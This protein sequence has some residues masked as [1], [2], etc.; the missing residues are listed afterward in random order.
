MSDVKA[1]VIFQNFRHQ[2]VHA[3][4]N[5]RQQHQNVGALVPFSDG[6][7]HGGDLPAQ[8]FDAGKQ[9]LFLIRNFREFVLH[10]FFAIPRIFSLTCTLGGYDIKDS[11]GKSVSLARL[12]A[13][14]R[15]TSSGS[16]PAERFAGLL[17]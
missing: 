2:A 9:L 6:A 13:R 10:D 7:L 15:N 12:Q 8:T 17:V 11:A 5:R 16:E 14:R 4:P 1:D 3:A